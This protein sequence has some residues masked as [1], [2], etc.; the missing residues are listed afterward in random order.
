MNFVVFGAV[1][2]VI[3]GLFVYAF[4]VTAKRADEAIEEMMEQYDV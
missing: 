3:G 1:C 2:F 4:A